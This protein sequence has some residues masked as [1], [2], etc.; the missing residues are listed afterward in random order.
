MFTAGP[1]GAIIGPRG[2]IMRGG[3]CNEHGNDEQGQKTK[4]S[5]N[6]SH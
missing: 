6:I 4:I 2:P 3:L 5:V 1:R